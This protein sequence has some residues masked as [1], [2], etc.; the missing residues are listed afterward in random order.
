MTFGKYGTTG[1][2]WIL[3]GALVSIGGTTGTTVAAGTAAPQEGTRDDKRIAELERR[4][5]ELEAM[6]RKALEG[7]TSPEI[8]ELKRKLDLLTQELEKAR[9]GEAAQPKALESRHGLGPAASKVYGVPRGVSIG[10]YGEA[11]L[12]DF[13]AERDDG[14]RSGRQSIADMLRAVVY[15]GYK[16]NDTIIFNSEIE[17]EHA[18]TGSGDEDLGEVSVEFANIDFML[19]KPANVRAGLLLV[20]VGFINEMHEPPTFL[21]ARRPDVENRIIPATWREMGV[22]VFGDAG[23]FSYRGYVVTGFNAAGFSA[24]SGLRDGRQS[25]SES[26]ARD[27]AFTAR[28]DYHG[29]PGLLVGASFYQGDSGQGADDSTGEEA[30]DGAVTLYDVHAEYNFKGLQLRGLWTAVNVDD[31]GEINE[32]L[33]G[34]DPNVPADATAGVGSRLTG[35]YLQAGYDLLSWTDGTEQ[36]VIP[37]VRYERYDTQDRLPS[38]FLSTGAN[39]VK[40]ITYG[41]SWKPILNLAI[42]VDFQDYDRSSGTGTD[43]FNAA[44]GYLF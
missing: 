32:T 23:P 4:V 27:L 20:P 24:G 38:G 14:E 9:M 17:F 36:S 44:I 18:T 7:S 42:K 19:S 21:G 13:S 8:A 16:F 1:A 29:V 2:A 25:G 6:L 15:F 35:W 30:I 11:L 31:A 10:G 28:A 22:G 26:L 43:Q 5:A 39:D 41:V 40:L 37:F 12:Q 3:A 34:L 33:L